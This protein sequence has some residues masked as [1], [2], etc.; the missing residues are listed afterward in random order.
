MK[1]DLQRFVH[2]LTRQTRISI[3]AK[4]P[5]IRVHMGSASTDCVKVGSCHTT[6][7]CVLSLFCVIVTAIKVLSQIKTQ[8]PCEWAWCLF[9][10][11]FAEQELANRFSL[12]RHVRTQHEDM[13]DDLFPVK[14]EQ[15][16]RRFKC[17]QQLAKWVEWA[18]FEQYGHLCQF[19]FFL[20]W[21]CQYY[22]FL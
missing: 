18:P 21:R 1:S 17:A 10:H 4:R 7:E 22:T 15:C 11:V 9:A 14:C 13:W 12:R 19:Y 2:T 20:D 5:N 6:T 8:L 16:G 3:D